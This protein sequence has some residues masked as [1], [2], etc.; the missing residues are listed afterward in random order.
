M[1]GFVLIVESWY[2]S[3]DQAAIGARRIRINLDGK[4]LIIVSYSGQN[5]FQSMSRKD[6][7]VNQLI[8]I[9][10]LTGIIS[11]VETAKMQAVRDL[12]HLFLSLIG[13]PYQPHPR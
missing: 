5:Q 9:R 4:R 1:P 2:E 8:H 13:Q 11:N 6:T 12:T 7:V 3:Y 10:F